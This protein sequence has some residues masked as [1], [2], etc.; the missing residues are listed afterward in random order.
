M[1][2]IKN[3]EF[4]IKNYSG[5][6]LFELLV[7]IS[8]IAVLVAVATASYSGAQKKA[9]DARRID[10]LNSIQKAAEMYYSQNGYVYPANTGDFTSSGVLQSWPSDPKTTNPYTYQPNTPA[11]GGYC[12]CTTALDSQ[13]GGNS[14][15]G[16]CSA[17]LPSNTGI[18]YCVK[19][20]Q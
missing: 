5:Y 16:N 19:N 3:L 15:A 12:V 6:T 8:I 7:S 13:T 9:R 18:F 11:A 14:N 1:K 17:F 2:L 10:D 20:Q 4:K